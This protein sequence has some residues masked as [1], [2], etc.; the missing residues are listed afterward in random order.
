MPPAKAEI[1]YDV[2]VVGIAPVSVEFEGPFVLSAGIGVVVEGPDA[3]G[4]PL[5]L[6]I[7]GLPVVFRGGTELVTE[8]PEAAVSPLSFTIFV[9]F[10]NGAEL[11]ANGPEATSPPL[12]LMIEGLSVIFACGEESVAEGPGVLVTPL[13]LIID[14]A[15]AGLVGTGVVAVGPKVSDPPSALIGKGL[16]V[17]FAGGREVVIE[18]CGTFVPPLILV[19][20]M[21]FV[22]GAE[23]IT[24]GSEAIVPPLL[25]ADDGIFAEL[26][27]IGVLAEDPEL[28]GPPLSGMMDGLS[29]PFVGAVEP[30]IVGLELVV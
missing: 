1:V 13:L 28:V 9:V 12:P 25:L 27:A 4:A 14:E 17:V 19:V 21:L 20:V 23:L 8:G 15:L 2:L 30:M 7:E 10:A 24:E 26:A 11:V 18:G 16:S 3:I 29:V 5:S 22:G 6:D